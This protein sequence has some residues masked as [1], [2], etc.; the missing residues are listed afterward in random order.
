MNQTRGIFQNI[1]EMLLYKILVISSIDLNDEYFDL[2][3]SLSDI[4]E[5][6]SLYDY[7]CNDERYY[8][9]KL[10]FIKTLCIFTL[11]KIQKN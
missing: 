4:G 2:D 10:N 5:T 8:L 7:D 3:A 9:S 6:I 1:I 11:V